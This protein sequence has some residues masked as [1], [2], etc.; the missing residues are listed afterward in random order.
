MQNIPKPGQI[1]RHFKGNLYRIV[2]LAEHSETGEA[3]VIYQALYGE[4]KVYARPLSMFMERLDRNKYQDAA[5]EMRFTLQEELIAPVVAEM[6][7]EAGAGAERSSR[8]ER[9]AGE[10][11][12][13]AAGLTD[14]EESEET[15]S[16]AA[17][18]PIPAQPAGSTENA[19]IETADAPET[20][21]GAEESAA[22]ETGFHLDPLVIEFLDADTCEKRLNILSALRE[23]ITDDMINIMAISVGVEIKEGDVERRYDEL[24]SCLLTFGKYESNRLR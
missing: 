23:R 22:D 12:A 13:G 5:A 8:T 20:A 1:Y 3:L 14:A 21:E 19:D 10:R 6:K 7:P 17:G 4:Y 24:R 16:K 2:T 9:T 15:G 11:G 18:A